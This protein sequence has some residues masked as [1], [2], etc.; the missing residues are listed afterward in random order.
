L[1]DAITQYAN[2]QISVGFPTPRSI[3]RR[4][5]Y[6]ALI[7]RK[8]SREEIQPLSDSSLLVMICEAAQLAERLTTITRPDQS[9]FDQLLAQ[10]YYDDARLSNR[11]AQNCREDTL[12]SRQ[13][14]TRRFA[15]RVT[16]RR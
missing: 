12:P 15:D 10:V 9:L 8:L 1:D 4:R 6:R 16:T 13:C 2:H 14:L 11:V 3:H 7:D 5:S